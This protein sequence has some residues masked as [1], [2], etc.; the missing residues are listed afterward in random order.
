MANVKNANTALVKKW[1]GGLSKNKKDPAAKFPRPAN[2][3]FHTNM[4]ITWETFSTNAQKLGY[5]ADPDLFVKMP[6]DIWL[7]IYKKLF[8]DGIKGDDINSQAIAEFM[9]EWAWGSGPGTAGKKLQEY[10]NTQRPENPLKVDGKIGP[11]TIEALHEI[12]RK[13]GE[14]IVFED[15]DRA[16]RNFLN[17]LGTINLFGVGWYHRMDDFRNY[18]A[19]II[20]A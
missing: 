5:A 11:K 15:L 13:K 9:T 3:E 14:R 2:L 8:W 4:G 18:A 10:I 7:K 17:T 1:E 12:I 20:P 16:K 6:E 19:Q